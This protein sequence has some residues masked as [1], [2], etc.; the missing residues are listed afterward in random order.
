MNNGCAPTAAVVYFITKAVMRVKVKI[1][2]L[3]TYLQYIN[4]PLYYCFDR[5][6]YK[7]C[8][9]SHLEEQHDSFYPRYIPLLQIDEKSIEKSFILSL[10]DKRILRMYNSPDFNFNAFVESPPERWARWWSYYKTTVFDLEKEW[11]E[12]HSIKYIYDL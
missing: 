5:K 6:N 3:F 7:I 10:N 8:D 9:A 12:E 1:S 4:S 2:E 11:C